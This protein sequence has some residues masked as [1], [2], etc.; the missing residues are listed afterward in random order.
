MYFQR[1]TALTEISQIS[2]ATGGGYQLVGQPFYF[3][4]QM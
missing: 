2:S 1:K 4:K 3:Q